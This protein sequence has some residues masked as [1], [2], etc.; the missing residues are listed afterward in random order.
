VSGLQG[1]PVST[2]SPSA[3]DVLTWNGIA[4]APSA[5]TNAFSANGD[6][7]GNNVS[8]QVISLSGLSDIV[9]VFCDNIN[10]FS[11]LSPSITQ[12]STLAGNGANFNIKAQSTTNISSNGGNV[13]ISGGNSGSSGMRG[14]V[15]LKIADTINSSIPVQ[16]VEVAPFRRVLSLMHT[17]NLTGSDMPA[18]TGDM[19]MYVR[20]AVT[21]PSAGSPVNGTIVYSSGGQLW[22]KQADGSNFVVGST[23]N[24]NIW[25]ST[26]QQVYSA[27]NYATTTSTSTA[28][29]FNVAIASGTAV[30]VETTIIGRNTSTNDVASFTYSMGYV[31]NGVTLTAIGTLTTIDSRTSAGA[32]GWTAPT[33]TTSGAHV[34]V[35]TGANAATTINW[36]GVTNLILV[37]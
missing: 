8:Q 32:S 1:N 18:S 5:A 4:W 31:S 37:A 26:G 27:K 35:L 7:T 24:P 22:I 29:V 36:L 28:Q 16:A 13:I 19:V 12:T 20:D 30:N 2:L 9:S 11:T 34:I 23:P 25:G 10:F 33:V 3:G 21:P 15:L 17:G 14:G 6:L